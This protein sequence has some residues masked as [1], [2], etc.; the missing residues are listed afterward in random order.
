MA[1]VSQDNIPNSGK[2]KKM[3]NP[4][5]GVSAIQNNLGSPESSTTGDNFVNNDSGQTWHSDNH[6]HPLNNGLGEA[7]FGKG[8]PQD[9]LAWSV[10]TSN[11]DMTM[12]YSSLDIPGGGGSRI[13]GNLS[14]GVY[15]GMSKEAQ[16]ASS[17]MRTAAW[18]SEPHMIRR[19]HEKEETVDK[20]L[21]LAT[22]P[23]GTPVS[24][25]SG[26]RYAKHLLSPRGLQFLNAQ[27]VAQKRN[28]FEH[29]RTV[30]PLAFLVS[31][32]LPVQM[33]RHGDNKYSELVDILTGGTPLRSLA[34]SGLQKMSEDKKAWIGKK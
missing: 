16:R 32:S 8:I 21:L 31:R 6:K 24:L 34:I 13:Q 2:I 11:Q 27:N 26:I 4:T 29:T 19:P 25:S 3:N 18:L 5:K 20:I 28:V 22:K 15:E 9:T 23:F 33:N 10:S 7:Q 14:D 12:T 30:N 1:I 17:G